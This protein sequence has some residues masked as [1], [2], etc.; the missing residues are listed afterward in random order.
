MPSKYLQIAI[1]VGLALAGVLIVDRYV[2]NLGLPF[3]NPLRPTVAPPVV[4]VITVGDPI[5][6]YK[7][8]CPPGMINDGYGC[9]S[10]DGLTQTTLNK[11]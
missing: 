4:G 1:A 6:T 7:S 3:A 2:T 9:I 5:V 11:V 8:K 10:D